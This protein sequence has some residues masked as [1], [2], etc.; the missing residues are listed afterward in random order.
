MNKNNYLIL[1]A[2]AIAGAKIFKKNV[3]FNKKS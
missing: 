1:K 3:A 2:L